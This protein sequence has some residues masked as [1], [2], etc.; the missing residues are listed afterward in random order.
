VN[1]KVFRQ[2]GTTLGHGRVSTGLAEL[3]TPLEPPATGVEVVATA[4]AEVAGELGALLSTVVR[5]S[6]TGQMVVETATVTTV[7]TTELAGQLGTVGSHLVM[8]WV[9]VVKMVDVLS[10]LV[11]MV[12]VTGELVAGDTLVVSVTCSAEV[13]LL[14]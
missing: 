10:K 1:K 13:L 14:C 5:V 2:D 11:V 6:V 3:T 4:G 7:V 12:L 8:V 9:L